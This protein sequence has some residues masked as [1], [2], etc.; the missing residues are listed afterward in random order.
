MHFVKDFIYS[1]KL[2]T[3]RK[4]WICGAGKKGRQLAAHLA[5]ETPIAGFVD[6]APKRINKTI[7][8]IRVSGSRKLN[9]IESNDFFIFSIGSWNPVREFQQKMQTENM[10][11]LDDYLVL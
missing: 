8:G 10:K 11:P 2:H 4:I 6:V 3:S 5:P 1:Q 7:N 9:Q